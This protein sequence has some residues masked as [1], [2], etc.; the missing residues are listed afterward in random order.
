MPAK[1]AQYAQRTTKGPD[2]TRREFAPKGQV[3]LAC[4]ARRGVCC[5]L[6]SA[7]RRRPARGSGVPDNRQCGVHPAGVADDL[8]Q[9]RDPN[10]ASRQE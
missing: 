4:R 9:Y 7:P 8:P 3:G 1:Q 5:D 2:R 6:R 10:G